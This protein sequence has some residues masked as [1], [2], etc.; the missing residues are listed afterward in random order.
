MINA[1]TTIVLVFTR[2]VG[3]IV[4]LRLLGGFGLGFFWP[5]AEVLVT[6]LAPVERRV[7]EV[8]HY[9]VAWASAFLVGPLIWGY[10]IQNLSYI[11]LFVF[12]T[13]LIAVALA[14]AV[15]WIAP[16]YKRKIEMRPDFSGS[17]SIIRKLASWYLMI[18]CYGIVFSVIVSIFPGY[19]NSLGVTPTIIGFIYTIFG[20]SRIVAFATSERYVRFGEK[21]VLLFGSAI[22][23]AGLLLIGLFSNTAVY[24]LSSI[25]LGGSFGIIFPITI[26][27]IS[28]HFPNERL[29]I[30][31]GSYEGVFGIGF[32]TGPVLAGIIA[33]MTDVSLSFLYMSLFGVLMIPF[34]ITARTHQTSRKG[35]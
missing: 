1:L 32:T 25:L 11:A 18:L 3:D 28:R 22:L 5:S 17:G 9:S 26:S 13:V 29:G 31:V 20:I 34:V 23:A 10:I 15:F 7:R 2:S 27:L 14:F 35:P 16:G 4:L 30:A 19:A 8:G 6:D 12:S 24:L 33:S 21:R